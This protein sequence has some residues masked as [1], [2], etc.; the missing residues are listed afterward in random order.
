MAVTRRDQEADPTSDNGGGS[1]GFT[2]RYAKYLIGGGFLLAGLIIFAIVWFQPQ[3]LFIE[4]TANEARP[5]V[6]APTSSASAL[7][8]PATVASGSFRS[9]EHRTTGRAEIIKLADGSHV[10]RFE[11]LDTS[12]GPDLRVYLSELPST[13]GW[14]DYG[15]RYIELD[16]LKANRGNANYRIPAGTAI[17]RY[18]SAV[19]WCVRFAVGFGVAP[20]NAA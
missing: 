5:T 9:L 18:K 12:N 7:A 19:I 20:L 2:S 11:N 16:K 15:R 6:A 10:L 14:H 3:K 13:L 4:E 1:R 8:Q 17:T